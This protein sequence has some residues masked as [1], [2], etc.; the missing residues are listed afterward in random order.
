A[1]T[2]R[3]SI[4]SLRSAR[5]SSAHRSCRSCGT[6]GGHCGTGS[7]PKPMHGLRGRRSNGR[8]PHHRRRRTSTAPCRPFARTVLSGTSTTLRRPMSDHGATT[9][10]TRDLAVQWRTF[11]GIGL[12]ILVIAVIYWFSSY[13]YAGTVMLGL[14]SG[15]SFLSAGYL[16]VQDRSSTKPHAA[17]EGEVAAERQ[18]LHHAS[19]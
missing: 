4:A 15:L 17:V 5:S 3:R 8:L 18:Y 12:F 10:A 7:G 19:L 16:F 13:D 1:T 9:S 14:A 11:A 6:Y 2:S